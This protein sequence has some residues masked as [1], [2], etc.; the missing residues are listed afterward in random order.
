MELPANLIDP[1]FVP[2][3]TYQNLNLMAA[4]HE[5]QQAG[6]FQRTRASEIQRW[7]EDRQSETNCIYKNCATISETWIGRAHV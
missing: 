6:T 2:N 3:A 5:Q 7:T 1:Y 4:K